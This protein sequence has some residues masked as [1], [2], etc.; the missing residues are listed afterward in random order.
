MP[1]GGT[2]RRTSLSPILF[3]ALNEGSACSN[4]K[5]WR[6][7]S[8]QEPFELLVC[9]NM[10][11]RSNVGPLGDTL[12]SFCNTATPHVVSI[13]FIKLTLLHLSPRGQDPSIGILDVFQHY[14]KM[15]RLLKRDGSVLVM[16]LNMMVLDVFLVVLRQLILRFR[17]INS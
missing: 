16:G 11:F 13:L 3:F 4:P 12:R 6:I 17:S 10:K 1:A 2:L 8:A 5:S 14:V 9:S 7:L 15:L